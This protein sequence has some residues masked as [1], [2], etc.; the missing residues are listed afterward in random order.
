MLET[1]RELLT[2]DA[3]PMVVSNCMAV[4]QKVSVPHPHPRKRQ[5]ELHCRTA[6]GHKP[7]LAFP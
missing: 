3:D 5:I 7:L 4:I 6:L 2:S 1:V